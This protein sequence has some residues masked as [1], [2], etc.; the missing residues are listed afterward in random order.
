MKTFSYTITDEIGIH[1]RPAGLLAKKAKE[2]ES[3]CTIEKGGKS[4]NITKLMGLGVKQGDT[5][6]VTCEGADEDKA[7]EA[8]K[9]F[10]EE[11]L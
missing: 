9:A 2:F 1:A 8:L 4:V 7:S 3:V 11:T 5:V 6:T 10:F